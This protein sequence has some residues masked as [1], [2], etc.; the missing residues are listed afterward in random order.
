M[1]I[2]DIIIFQPSGHWCLNINAE[3]IS[4]PNPAVILKD[5]V[6]SFL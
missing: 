6:E 2:L 3:Y 4:S 5:M 1:I